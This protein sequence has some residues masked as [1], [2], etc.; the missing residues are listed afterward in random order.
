MRRVAPS[1]GRRPEWMMPKLS[2]SL[3]R[4]LAATPQGHPVE[5]VVEVG[6]ATGASDA[7]AAGGRA[8][9]IEALKESFAANAAPIERAIERSGGEVL[10]RAWLNQSLKARLPRE[11]VEALSE[12]EDI[13]RLD[14]P[15][16]LQ[17]D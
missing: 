10:G 14:M 2:P 4:R 13:E 11:A 8:K 12:R 6:K 9:K 5:V 1:R 3:R 15:A 16:T 17:P 7:A